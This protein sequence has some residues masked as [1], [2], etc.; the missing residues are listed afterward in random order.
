MKMP[1][2]LTGFFQR[3]GPHLAVAG[4]II[5]MGYAM[6]SGQGGGFF[7]SFQ[8][9]EDSYWENRTIESTWTEREYLNEEGDINLPPAGRLPSLQQAMRENPAL[10]AKVNEFSQRD[11]AYLFANYAQADA[12][13]ATILLLWGGADVNNTSKSSEGMDNRVERFLRAVF[14]ESGPLTNNPRMGKNPWPRLFLHYKLRLI[15][16]TAGGKAPFEGELRY[17]TARDR[18]MMEGRL[19]K[20]FFQDFGAFLKSRS[21]PEPF[22]NNLVYYVDQ[23]RPFTSLSAAENEAIAFLR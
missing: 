1:A 17:D 14:Q 20:D 10:R 13:V 11:E 7:S 4:L 18:I 8:S 15:A 6:L 12:D 3:F 23:I 9:A 2:P 19:S 22:R 5:V 21:D 16:Q